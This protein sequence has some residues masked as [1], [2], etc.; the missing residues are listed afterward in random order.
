MSVR[1]RPDLGGPAGPARGRRASSPSWWSAWSGG[2]DW[3][4]V[5]DALTHLALV[6]RPD[7][8]RRR[9]A[10]PPGAQ[11]AA[12]G[13]LHPGRLALPG[14]AQR[15]GRD[16][17][18]HGRAAAERPRAADGD[19]LVVGR[20]RVPKALAGTVMN[21]LTFYIVRF[22]AP[23]VG[24]AAA[25][26]DRSDRPGCGGPTCSASRSRSRS[27]SGLLLV[28]RSERA[29]PPGRHDGAARLVAPG[30][31]E[32]RPGSLGRGL[33][34]VPRSTSPP[35]SATG[36]RGRCSRS[37][38]CSPSTSRCWPCA[39]GSSGSSASE[40]GVRRDRDRLPVRLPVHDLPVLRV[41]ASS[42][43]WSS[44]RSSRPGES[45]SRGRLPSPA[46]VVWR[47]FTIG[48]PLALGALGL[49]AWRR[50]AGAPATSP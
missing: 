1:G 23:A 42:T 12:A 43:P 31:Q 25:R 14:D 29:G 48:G 24:F 2:I 39:C 44:P 46:L 8:A 38:A 7:R 5:R 9:A 11:R 13:A 28:V 33:R 15:P 30:P 27:S 45:S 47:V 40:V 10:G 19:V 34:A 6:A 4:E 35:G 20:A 16:P 17:D 22:G 3:G 36:S 49:A 26:G 18:V 32:R 41:S 37:A 21:T 50:G